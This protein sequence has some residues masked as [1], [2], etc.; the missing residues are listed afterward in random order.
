MEPAPP[1]LDDRHG[2]VPAPADQRG[3]AL[4]LEHLA[5]ADVAVVVARVA[6]VG[7]KGSARMGPANAK[8]KMVSLWQSAQAVATFFSAVFVPT[9][10][11]AW[12]TPVLALSPA[13]LPAVGRWYT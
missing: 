8:W 13:I 9:W 2:A 11:R 7:V 4:V 3:A 12:P 5:G 6:V 10:N 1:S